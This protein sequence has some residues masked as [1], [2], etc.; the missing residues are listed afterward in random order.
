MNLDFLQVASRF[1]RWHSGKGSACQRKRHK[2]CRFNSWVRKSRKWQATPLF[3]PGKFH[4]WRSLVGY[5]PWGRKESDTT[6]QLHFLSFC[7]SFWRRKWQP[8]P[9]FLPEESHG[10]RGL[11]DYS[12]WGCK[13]SDTTKQLT[14]RYTEPAF[15]RLSVMA[16]GGY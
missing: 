7:S 13:E 16:Y 12:L 14:H 1:P 3:L 4:R 2:K 8:T 11:V 10:Q 9:V 6:E 5:S 15:S